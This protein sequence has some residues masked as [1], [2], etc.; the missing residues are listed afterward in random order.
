MA[1]TSTNLEQEL[2]KP[3]FGSSAATAAVAS[4]TLELA[5]LVVS[6]VFGKVVP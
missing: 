1:K 5:D 2:A 4:E 6:E 3:L